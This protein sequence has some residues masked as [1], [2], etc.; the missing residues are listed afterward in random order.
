MGRTTRTV[1]CREGVART[2][3]TVHCREGVVRTQKSAELTVRVINIGYS[4]IMYLTNLKLLSKVVYIMVESQ[5]FIIDK[6][7]FI[8]RRVTQRS[9]Y[10]KCSF[11]LYSKG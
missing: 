2:T 11:L 7:S 10:A 1:H 4:I 6:F 3:H 9:K 5:T 8:Y